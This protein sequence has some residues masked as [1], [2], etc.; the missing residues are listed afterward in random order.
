MSAPSYVRIT[1]DRVDSTQDVARAAFVDRAVLVSATGQDRGRGRSGRDWVDADRLVA[2]SLAVRL[3]WAP[4]ARPAAGLASALA[5]AEALEEMAGPGTIRLKWP[6][7]LLLGGAKVGG[8]IAEAHDDLVVFGFGANLWWSDPIDGAGSV[9]DHDPGP[10][11]SHAVAD[12]WASRLLVRLIGGPDAWGLAN[13][14]DRS[15]TI[16]QEITWEPSGRGV[17]V[18][19]ASDGGLVVDTPA[20]RTVLHSGE[21]STVRADGRDS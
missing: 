12:D 21:V 18:G 9:V 1:R 16:G 17:A 8:L 13:Y 11:A 14:V 10:E 20:G 5:A 3:D 19:V 4:T 6:N 2:A 7:D 15:A